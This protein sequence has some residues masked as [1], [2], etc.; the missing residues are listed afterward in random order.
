MTAELFTPKLAPSNPSLCKPSYTTQPP[1]AETLPWVPLV[2]SPKE[3]GSLAQ[4]HTARTACGLGV[5]VLTGKLSLGSFEVESHKDD[6]CPP[7]T[8]PHCVLAPG[9]LPGHFAILGMGTT[10]PGHGVP[11]HHPNMEE[12]A[13]PSWEMGDSGHPPQVQSPV[14]PRPY[15]CRWGRPL[16]RVP[17]VLGQKP[18]GIHPTGL[19]WC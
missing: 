7:P 12:R 15:R 13:A 18:R 16:L 3:V 2:L 9:G 4:G 17:G 8:P 19:A 1:P 10:G 14:P 6:G 5:T 11:Q